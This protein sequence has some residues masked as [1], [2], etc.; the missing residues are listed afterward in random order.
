[1]DASGSTVQGYGAAEIPTSFASHG[2]RSSKP[3]QEEKGRWNVGYVTTMHITLRLNGIE[4]IL[5]AI[6]AV[7]GIETRLTK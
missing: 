3:P 1:V 2:G 6:R 5:Q 4:T 7:F